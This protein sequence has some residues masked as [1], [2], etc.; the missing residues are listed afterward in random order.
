MSDSDKPRK[1]KWESTVSSRKAQTRPAAEFIKWNSCRSSFQWIRKHLN[2]DA[3]PVCSARSGNQ[4]IGGICQKREVVR[5]VK[6]V[7][8]V[9][10]I[11]R[12]KGEKYIDAVRF[13]A[14]AK[15]GTPLLLPHVKP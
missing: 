10:Y 8:R 15:E 11:Q 1:S 4:R 2:W 3:S 13:I 14:N 7:R 5:G 9:S 6:A 12:A